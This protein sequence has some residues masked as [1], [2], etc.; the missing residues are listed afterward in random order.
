MASRKVLIVGGVGSS[1]LKQRLALPPAIR[2]STRDPSKASFPSNL[3][4]VH[5]DLLDA[6]SYTTLFRGVERAFLY[7][8]P[9]A[10]LAQLCSTAN[11]EGLKHIVL[12]SSYTV[13]TNPDI[14]IGIAHK[15]VEDAV[16]DS[17]LLQHS[18]TMVANGC[19]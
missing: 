9:T 17:F 7:A 6:S 18:P 11:E 3:E 16:V 4:V 15:K 10:S 5:G 14:E 2:V 8:K 12:L 1:L 13:Q 19:Q